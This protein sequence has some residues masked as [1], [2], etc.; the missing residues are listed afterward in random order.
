MRSPINSF[1]RAT[2][3][4]FTNKVVPPLKDNIGPLRTLRVTQPKHSTQRQLAST[5]YLLLPFL[6]TLLRVSRYVLP[7]LLS[8]RAP[9][10]LIPPLPSY[11][12]ISIATLR[13]SSPFPPSH[14]LPTSTHVER[15]DVLEA[16]SL[17]LKPRSLGLPNFSSPP[18]SF[19][20]RLESA[21][22][23]FHLRH[24]NTLA[25][26]LAILHA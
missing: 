16:T 18:M 10:S 22:E 15:S 6:Q 21:A 20:R 14:P 2:F 17:L 13:C 8:S 4:F 1:P 11:L 7:L 23:F 5:F 3:S 25:P 19:C 12:E 9:L 24:I 26:S